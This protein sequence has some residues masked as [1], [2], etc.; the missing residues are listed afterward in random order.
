MTLLHHAWWGV[1]LFFV[2]SGFSL[3]LAHLRAVEEKKATPAGAFYLRR[4]ARIV[5]GFLAALGLVLVTHPSWVVK[6]GFA[7]ALV[8]HL[9]LL[10]GYTGLLGGFVFIGASWT[11]TTEAQFYVV[12]PLLARRLLERRGW[13][14]GAALVVGSWLARGAL[15]ALVLEPG[16]HTGLW[17]LTQRRLIVSRFDQFVLGALA[18]TAY[19]AIER[20]T[21]LVRASRAAP[22]VLALALPALVVAFRLEGELYLDRGG[23][24]PYALMS[25]VTTVIVLAVA[26]TRGRAARV[27]SF[28]PLAAIGLVSYG[29]FLNHQLVLGFVEWFAP[30]PSRAPSWP[31]FAF[32]GG[33]A[34]ALSSLVGLA[35]WRMVERPGLGALARWQRRTPRISST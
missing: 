23:S 27:L 32:V 4:V 20:S 8:A 3:G 29:I 21:A 16:V 30:F 11:L 26:L 28:R 13:R 2:L 1:D 6:D 7:S 10:Q 33:V 9:A 12:F 14:L 24:W 18:A 15:H 17:E 19:V 5:P 31:R 25:L 35:S 34:L 22:W